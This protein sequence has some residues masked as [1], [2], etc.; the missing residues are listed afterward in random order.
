MRLG[1]GIFAAAVQLTEER[2]GARRSGSGGSGE[3]SAAATS[4]LEFFFVF[5]L[6]FDFCWLSSQHF[7][8][9]KTLYLVLF[10]RRLSKLGPVLISLHSRV[11]SRLGSN[12]NEKKLNMFS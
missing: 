2:G 9:C 8:T 10:L 7:L 12:N 1:R 4:F 3:G 6:D 11:G 5:D